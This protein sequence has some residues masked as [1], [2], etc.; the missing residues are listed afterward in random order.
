MTCL[1]L[2]HQSNL[3]NLVIKFC[4]QKIIFPYKKNEDE[5]VL[6]ILGRTEYLHL[7]LYELLIF[8]FYLFLLL[9]FFL[10]L[11]IINY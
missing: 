4:D 1:G 8:V 10:Y 5:N 9:L 3:Y 7:T 11:L 6:P 2:F